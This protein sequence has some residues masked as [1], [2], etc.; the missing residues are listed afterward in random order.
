M[1]MHKKNRFFPFNAEQ[2][3]NILSEFGPLVSMF[4]VNAIYADTD[5]ELTH[6][7]IAII[8]TTIMAIIAMKAVLKRYPVF[9]L[10][11][12]G[13]TIAFATLALA[14]HNPM[15]IQLKVTVFNALFAAFLLFGLWTG[16]NF[17][18]YAFEKTFH[19]SEKGWNEFTVSFAVFFLLTAVANEYVRQ[20]FTGATLYDVLGHRMSGIDIWVFF[21]IA[22]VLPVSGLYGWI[23]TRLMQKHRLPPSAAE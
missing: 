3:I 2:T 10:I 12:S 6:G 5:P 15:W 16:R 8:V 13:V 9:P 20:T 11:A 14:T 18:K 7:T 4:I 22:I 19:Y 23:M 1:D 21:K 17:F